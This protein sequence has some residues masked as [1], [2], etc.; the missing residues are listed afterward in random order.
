DM[1][2]HNTA[3]GESTFNVAP[4]GELL[5]G[6]GID[7]GC[8]IRFSISSGNRVEIGYMKVFW[9]TAPL[10]L[11]HIKQKSAFKLKPG[12]MRGGCIDCSGP[13]IEWG[14]VSLP[15]VLQEQV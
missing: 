12:D 11:D 8:P 14:V 3:R 13:T 15:L 1:F 2:G 7:G 4:G 5:I 6:D 10:E 9:S